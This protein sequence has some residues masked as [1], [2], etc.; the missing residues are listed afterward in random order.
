M[1]SG[2]TL[3]ELLPLDTRAL[4]TVLAEGAPVDPDVLADH[5]YHGV[6]LGLSQ[7][8]ERL[9]W[10]TFKKVF[11]HD[12]ERGVLRGWN[13]RV[14]QHGAR[15]PFVDRQRRGRP[16]TFG[17]FHV[18]PPEGV[19]AG[20]DRGLLIDYGAGSNHPLDPVGRL[21]DPIVSLDG[22]A[23][24]RLLG[25]TYV[26]LGKLRIPTPSYF[27]LERGAPLRDPVPP[28]H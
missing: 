19:P 8:V 5:D 13:Q 23:S 9:T 14:E 28:P 20:C 24:H 25:W 17:H 2:I 18:V 27:Y 6:S 26:L 21:R 3:D 15:G 4:A 16:I 11:H 7:V 1:S 22:G 12:P 10:K